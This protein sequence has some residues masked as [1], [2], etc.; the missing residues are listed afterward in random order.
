MLIKVAEKHFANGSVYALKT[1]DGFLLEDEFLNFKL[2]I[3]CFK[4]SISA[5]FCSIIFK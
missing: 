1:E 4:Y 5:S 3:S 2:L